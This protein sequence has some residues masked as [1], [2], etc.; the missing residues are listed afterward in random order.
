MESIK[1]DITQSIY[2]EML[3]ELMLL[4][5]DESPSKKTLERIKEIKTV[6]EL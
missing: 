1:G 5:A 2:S 6:L 3:N 4:E